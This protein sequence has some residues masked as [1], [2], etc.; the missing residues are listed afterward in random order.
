M[1]AFLVLCRYDSYW[2]TAPLRAQKLLLFIMQRT[3]KN[4]TFVFGI[5][6]V[7]LRGFSTVIKT[8]KFIIAVS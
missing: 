5:F 2:Y 3:S 6:V 1:F 8:I 4:F 7:S